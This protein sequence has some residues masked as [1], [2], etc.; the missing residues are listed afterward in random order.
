M[1]GADE[2]WVKSA[3]TDDAMVVELLVRLHRAPPLPPPPPKPLE[4][5]VRQRRS[6][7]VPVSNNPKKRAHSHRGSPTTPLSW[8]GGTSFSGSSEESSRTVAFKL[9]SETRSKVC[10]SP[11]YIYVHVY[12]Y[13]I[14][15]M[16]SAAAYV[17]ISRRVGCHSI[18]TV[19][20]REYPL[21]IWM[22]FAKE[23]DSASGGRRRV[24]LLLTN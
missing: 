1:G 12:K 13:L 20:L 6:K 7:P 17:P 16:P 14:F 5:S 23:S 24:L 3:M 4:W 22:L 9:S 8:S 21:G 15:W 10:F 2:E 18:T 19:D 11:P